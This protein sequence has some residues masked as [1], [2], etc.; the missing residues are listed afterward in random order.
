MLL[1]DNEIVK[2]RGQ[3]VNPVLSLLDVDN[4]VEIEVVQQKKAGK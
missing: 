1:D 2:E 4:L 3:H